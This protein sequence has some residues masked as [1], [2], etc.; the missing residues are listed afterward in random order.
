VQ[1]E[2]YMRKQ[3]SMCLWNVYGSWIFEWT[4]YLCI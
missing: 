1:G 2:Q 3:N 4:R